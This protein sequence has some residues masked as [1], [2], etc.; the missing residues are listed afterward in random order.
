MCSQVDS[1]EYVFNEPEKA[2]T[3]LLHSKVNAVDNKNIKSQINSNYNSAILSS[4]KPKSRGNKARS[5]AA[6]AK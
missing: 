5:K 1:K 3:P 6:A 2:E 4:K